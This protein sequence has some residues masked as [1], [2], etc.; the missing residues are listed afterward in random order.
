MNRTLIGLSFGSG[1][2]GA[3]VAVVRATGIGL[4]LAPRVERAVRVAFPPVAREQIRTSGG[5]PSPGSPDSTEFIRHV[6]DTAV[7]AVR[8]VATQT[9]LSPRD[10][11][12]A[13]LLEPAR[14]ATDP[15]IDWPE[16]ADRVA[17]QTGLTVVHG[18]RGR[19]RAA[20]GCGHPITTVADYLLF[21][22][23]RE[24]RLHIHLG[25]AAG[26]AFIPPGAKVS[27]VL[28]FEAG[29]G[30]Q[31]LDALVCHGTRGREATDPGGK[32]AVQGC[33]LEPLLTRW[34][35]HPYLTRKPPKSIRP[36][37]FGRAFLRAAF[38]TTRQLGAGLPDLVCTATHL[39]ARGVGE[40]CRKW[41]PPA[42]A[43]RRVL[44]TGGGVRN[45]FL[46]Q[47]L[48]PQFD[49]VRLERAD[50]MGLP[51]LARNA[52]AA[53]VLAVLMCDGVTGNLPPLTGAAAGRLLGHLAPGDGRNW[54]R[55]AAWIADQ[56][57]NY[58][59]VNRAA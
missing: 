2:E 45:G 57:G 55:C 22:D 49:G 16:V 19:D 17:E 53:G 21:R 37:T 30:N 7:H 6:A 11:F 20:G 10:V 26:V 39:I 47:L 35:E 46:W 13:G 42:T 44:V 15:A 9:G 31:L 5:L 38:D 27:A 29:P 1:L 52:A 43:P 8:T 56:I 23:T 40:A 50:A 32:K 18:F 34:V 41:F 12:A 14:P 59:G 54:A 25:A 36:D 4:D 48:G 28:G 58:P 3:D 24:E 51:P 33:G